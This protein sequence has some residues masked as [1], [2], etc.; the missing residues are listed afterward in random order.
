M[1]T[2]KQAVQTPRKKAAVKKLAAKKA[3]VKRVGAAARR[4][5]IKA[6]QSQ[7]AASVKKAR[8]ERAALPTTVGLLGIEASGNQT[9]SLPDAVE[10]GLPFGAVEHLADELNLSPAVLG[11]KYLGITRPT[12]SRR[13]KSGLLNLS[14]S[15]ATVRYARLLKQATELMEGDES[16]ALQWLNTP[17]AILQGRAPMVHAR[18]EAGAREIDLLVGRLEHGVYS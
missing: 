15:D 18:T 1:S 7:L 2:A 11:E 13:R 8:A 14:E 10:H 5:Q 4:Q 9:V 3:A 12:L 6:M 17:L 16:A